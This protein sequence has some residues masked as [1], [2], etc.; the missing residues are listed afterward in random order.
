MHEYARDG[1]AVV[2]YYGRLDY[3]LHSHA[4]VQNILLSGQSPMDSYDI[5]IRVFRQKLKS[6]M[7]FIVKH[8]VFEKENEVTYFCFIYY[9]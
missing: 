2:R 9:Q 6:L 4:N 3:S 1:I 5:T 7:D 8:E